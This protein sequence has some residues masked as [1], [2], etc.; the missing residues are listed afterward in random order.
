MN[1]QAKG[2]FGRRSVML[3]LVVAVT[4]GLLWFGIQGVGAVSADGGVDAGYQENDISQE[5]Q[6][7]PNIVS[8]LLPFIP[9]T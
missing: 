1:I 6:Q 2:I 3:W 7:D 8:C 4:V 9:C 5:Y